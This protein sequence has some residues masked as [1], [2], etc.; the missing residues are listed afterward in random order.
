[1]SNGRHQGQPL[2]CTRRFESRAVLEVTWASIE[3]NVI[4]K[5][6]D[7][8]N[9]QQMYKENCARFW[10]SSQRQSGLRQNIFILRARMSSNHEQRQESYDT[11]TSR[12]PCWNLSTGSLSGSR[13]SST[14]PMLESRPASYV[15]KRIRSLDVMHNPLILREVTNPPPPQKKKGELN[16]QRAAGISLQSLQYFCFW[17]RL[18][19]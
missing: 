5:P 8:Y 13:L 9:I 15:F 11:V 2:T 4:C 19:R 18:G 7:I 12:W 10:V 16:V 3:K 14:S 1:M 17:P 6:Q